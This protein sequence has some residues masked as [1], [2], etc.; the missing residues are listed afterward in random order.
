[1]VFPNAESMKTSLTTELI[2]IQRANVILSRA[3]YLLL[4]S[5]NFDNPAHRIITHEDIIADV[6]IPQDTAPQTPDPLLS[7]ILLCAIKKAYN[8]PRL[9]AA[10]LTAGPLPYPFFAFST[11]PSLFAFFTSIDLCEAAGAI[12]VELLNDANVSQDFVY[13]LSLSFLLSSFSFS[14]AIWTNVNDELS[15]RV[16]ISDHLIA[17]ALIH[18]TCR[19]LPLLSH[20][21][22]ILI[23][24]LG[25][26][27][28]QLL[29]SVITK[30]LQIG[31]RL[32][33]NRSREGI[34]FQHGA[35]IL[36]YFNRIMDGSAPF[37]I[38]A[39]F[40][41]TI[42]RC[43]VLP[44]F[45]GYCRLSSEAL[46]FGACD[47]H[48]LVSAFRPI[49]KEIQMFDT[50]EQLAED[51]ACDR[52][53]P[54]SLAL[55]STWP[56]R[57]PKYPS[58]FPVPDASE[59][60]LE[61]VPLF[62][63]AY[64]QSA[65]IDSPEFRRYSLK[66]DFGTLREMAVD[67]EIAFTF[68]DQLSLAEG[69]GTS[70]R[71]LRGLVFDEYTSLHLKWRPGEKLDDVAAR[72]LAG[73]SETKNLAIS[74]LLHALSDGSS[75][76]LALPAGLVER[77]TSL[78]RSL[79]QNV[80]TEVSEIGRKRFVMA[81]LPQLSLRPVLSPAQKFQVFTH[82][83]AT[84]RTVCNYYAPR[85]VHGILPAIVRAVVISADPTRVFQ[86]FLHFEK[87]VFRDPEFLRHL[88]AGALSDWNNFFQVMWAACALQ[89]PLL[90]TCMGLEL[91]ASPQRSSSEG[92]EKES[93]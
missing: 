74:A 34:T 89:Q 48:L 71:R 47:L 57:V 30:F 82:A 83:F 37:D 4:F 88:N 81:L 23:C 55:F 78:S 7:Q 42:G 73:S 68:K 66:K 24:E 40:S 51:A 64:R 10:A 85:E 9:F 17:N 16:Q 1:M 79:F 11:F 32:W 69:I 92:T 18:A 91:S 77:W 2:S 50:F 28:P 27:W 22:H 29:E 54:L 13:Y 19:C 90:N 39:P 43:A 70:L 15:G 25:S 49:A 8:N 14:D 63:E 67:Q 76:S 46:I 93:G 87:V 53:R 45:T 56:E 35:A 12:L 36:D 80:W 31:F 44:S 59:Y 52:F 5:L 33:W 58:L 84:I 72:F 6:L 62:E 61:I 38:A 41:S 65:K 75:K 21:V 60:P 20:P 86:V 26:H 3:Y